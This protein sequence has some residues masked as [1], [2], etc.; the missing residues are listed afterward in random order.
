MIIMDI[1]EIRIFDKDFNWLAVC[2][3]AESVQFER[4]L[5]GAGRFEIHIHPDQKGAAELARRGNIIVIN[6][7]PHKS[8]IIRDFYIEGNRQAE[9][10]VIY[11]ETGNGLLGQRIVVPPTTAQ[12]PGSLGWD[13]VSGD[14]ETVLKHYVGRNLSAPFDVKRR[15]NNLV[16][17]ANL[18]R[19]VSFPWQA[20]YTPLIDELQSIGL[21]AEMGFEIYADFANRR[22][23]FD[24]IHGA[25]R[26]RAQDILSPVSFNMEYQNVD[27]YKYTESYA[28]FRN[29]GYAGGGG[30]DESRLIYIL[31]AGSEDVDRWETFLDCGNA[32]N[33]TELMYYG[34]QRL[35]A[36]TEA[37][38]VDV[39]TLPR[40]F[41]FGKD[42]FLGDLVTVYINR[43]GLSLDTRI[44]GARE[45]WE[46]QSGYKT[47]I[48]F[49]EKVPNL[50]T[51]LKKREVIL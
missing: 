1:C 47:E 37:K 41:T 13:R 30:T 43:I 39:N 34:N 8:G 24:V 11:G 7:D 46:R 21:Y 42:Y 9:K 3:L 25:D 40:V 12:V 48:R 15:I 36:Y 6:G 31:G 14:A 22:W 32:A 4:D 49:G 51:I 29:T 45:I 5:Y 19:G 2:K 26:T 18:N 20:R 35:A 50:F 28:N 10:F 44:T 38:T 17:A 23:M 27:S 16:V 33:I